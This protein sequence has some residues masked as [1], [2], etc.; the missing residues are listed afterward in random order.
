MAKTFP[1]LFCAF[2]ALA[3]FQSALASEKRFYALFNYSYLDL[4][5]P[6]K[7]GVS[8]GWLRNEDHSLQLEYLKGS[9]SAPWV[10]ED[11]GSVTDTRI[12]LIRRS[13]LWFDSFH[14]G[15]GLVYFDFKVFLGNE[16]L[17]ALSEDAPSAD[18][19]RSET[20][21]AYFSLGNRWNVGEDWLF[22]VDWFAWSQPLIKL[23]EESEFLDKADDENDRETLRDALRTIYSFPRLAVFKLAIGRKF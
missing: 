2:F 16:L 13:R 18:L 8:A 22:A 1:K 17:S 5:A 14:I 10:L 21:G 11:L 9:I 12:S 7:W 4:L 20:L 15:Y 6:G 3:A 23:R 19:A